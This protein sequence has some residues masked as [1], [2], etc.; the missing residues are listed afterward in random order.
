[1]ALASFEASLPLT[2]GGLAQ[3]VAVGQYTSEGTELPLIAATY[4]E[5]GGGISVLLGDGQGGFTRGAD[6]LLGTGA[7]PRNP[8]GILLGHFT[9]SGVDD[10]AVAN[11]GQGA[12]GGLAAVPGSVTVFRG[13]GTGGFGA[14]SDLP[15]PGDTD[16]RPTYLA[17]ATIGGAPYLF[18]ADFEGH[19][20]GD[21]GSNQVLVYRGDGAG[22]YA[23]RQRLGDVSGPDQ[24]VVADFNDDGVLDLAVANA[25]ADSVTLF[26]GQG[27]GTF[28]TAQIVPVHATGPGTVARPV[29]LAAGAFDGDTS[30]LDLAVADYGSGWATR[31]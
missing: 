21:P 24:I 19:T 2:V 23:L 12:T 28:T 1:V 13:D 29:G 31:S 25:T 3:L 5:Q 26:Q 6:I 17:A 16:V 18:V 11:F 8:E 22:H 9:D 20:P 30:H 10:L 27:D 7:A 15:L 4:Q 14:P